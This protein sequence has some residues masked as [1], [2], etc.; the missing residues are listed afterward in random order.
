LYLEPS[1][2]RLAHQF[3]AQ[4]GTSPSIMLLKTGHRF[5][6]YIFMPQKHKT[7]HK[8][9][10]HNAKKHIKIFELPFWRPERAR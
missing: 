7:K 8:T 1:S 10:H 6:K 9:T 2:T 5:M 4:L 3:I